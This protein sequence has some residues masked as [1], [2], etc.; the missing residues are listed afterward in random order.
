VRHPQMRRR[1][2]WRWWAW[3][4][5]CLAPLLVLG[6]AFKQPLSRVPELAMPLFIAG[7][8][9]L[10]ITLKLFRGYKRVL[11]ATR[12]SFDTDAEAA[13]W[14]A[15]SKAQW[16]GLI[17]AALPAWIG[18]LARCIG[19]DSLAA[20]LLVLASLVILLIYRLPRQLR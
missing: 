16:R 1:L 12:P 20:W 18:A 17:G 15:L 13:A 10:F 2:V 11:F 4:V 9:S 19:L 14:Q 3:L 6:L 8:L 5:L 7:C